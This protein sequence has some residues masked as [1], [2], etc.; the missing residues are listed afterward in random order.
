MLEFANQITIPRPITNN[1]PLVQ[2]LAAGDGGLGID[3]PPNTTLRFLMMS[4]VNSISGLG[5]SGRTC[6]RFPLF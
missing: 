1:A 3:L 5:V 6:K 2:F 4:D